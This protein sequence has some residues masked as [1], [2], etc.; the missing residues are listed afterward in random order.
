MEFSV[1]RPLIQHIY[2]NIGPNT[3]LY[4][5]TKSKTNEFNGLWE[6][7][8]N[9]ELLLIPNID[10]LENIYNLFTNSRIEME[11]IKVSGNSISLKLYPKSRR[12]V[13]STNNHDTIPYIYNLAKSMNVSNLNIVMNL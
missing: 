10:R 9:E 4:L 5:K 12:I 1:I 3:E 6:V 8:E 11:Y 13:Y 7:L 2:N